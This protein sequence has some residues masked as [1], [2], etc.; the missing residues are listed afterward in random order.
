MLGCFLSSVIDSVSGREGRD[1]GRAGRPGGGGGDARRSV[2]KR[3][4]ADHGG[5]AD[6]MAR[7]G[8][9]VMRGRAEQQRAAMR[10]GES[11]PEEYPAERERDRVLGG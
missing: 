2:I 9:A 7:R 6:G 4:Q 8:R 5:A 1:R 10:D 11:S 3:A